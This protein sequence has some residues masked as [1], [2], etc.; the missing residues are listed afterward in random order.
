[1]GVADGTAGVFLDAEEIPQWEPACKVVDEELQAAGGAIRAV[2]CAADAVITAS[3]R[4]VL[5]VWKVA[6]SKLTESQKLGHGAVGSSCVEV[7]G[8]GQ[9]VVVCSDDGSL[10]LW[11]LRE[12]KRAGEP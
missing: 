9:L 5:K 7:S 1:M 6:E 12:N 4:P 2:A 8:N 11:D 3:S 10:G